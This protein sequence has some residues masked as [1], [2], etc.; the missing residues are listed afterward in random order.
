MLRLIFV[1]LLLLAGCGRGREGDAKARQS[2]QAQAYIAGPE[3]VARAELGQIITGATLSGELLADETATVRA[4]LGGQVVEVSAS[5]GDRVGRGQLLARIEAISERESVRSAAAALNTARTEFTLA[6]R[7]EE[8]T[9]T[10]VKAGALAERDLEQAKAEVA[11]AQARVAQAEANLTTARERL[12]ESVVRSPID[13]RVSTASINRG[14]VVAIG[15]ELFSIIDLSTLEL[16]A[17]VPADSLGSLRVGAPVQFTIQGHGDRQFTGRITRISPAADRQ[18]NQIVVYASIPNPSGLLVSGLYAEGRIATGDR[19]A[20]IVPTDAVTMQ[21]GE[22]YVMALENG[23]AVR[24]PVR[25]GNEDAQTGTVQIVSGVQ[26]GQLLLAG[27]ARDVAPGARVEVRG[28]GAREN[29]SGGGQSPTASQPPN[30]PS[31]Q[32]GAEDE[33]GVPGEGRMQQAVPGPGGGG[34]QAQPAGRSRPPR[35]SPTG[36][37]RSQQ[38]LNQNT[39]A[40]KGS[41][42]TRGAAQPGPGR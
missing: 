15:A 40:T 12:S 32:T 33:A 28:G 19:S 25:L 21:G 14:D 41:P 13:G 1:L 4:Q 37:D 23:R 9:A 10:L 8:R 27:I 36:G 17:S 2:D 29:G 3:D 39:D 22:S 18:T 42:G 6:Q 35:Q 11:N 7:D 5:V 31:N 24:R 20:V 34:Q 38:N 16:Q 26:A 30:A